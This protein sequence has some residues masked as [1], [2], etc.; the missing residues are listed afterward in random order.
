MENNNVKNNK[1]ISTVGNYSAYVLGKGI[2]CYSDMSSCNTI[3]ATYSQ[4]GW[5]DGCRC[6]RWQ[7]L[8]PP[9]GERV[10]NFQC[11][12]Y[13]YGLEVKAYVPL[14]EVWANPLKYGV[15]YMEIDR[16]IN[17]SYISIYE[18]FSDYIDCIKSDQEDKRVYKKDDRWYY[19]MWDTKLVGNEL[20]AKGINILLTETSMRI[21]INNMLKIDELV[22]EL[23]DAE[24]YG[25][26]WKIPDPKHSIYNKR[27]RIG[28]NGC[29][30]ERDNTIIITYKY[31]LTPELLKLIEENH[32]PK[33]VIDDSNLWF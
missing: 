26:E 25:Y 28:T 32:K 18:L 33:E 12:R 1:T 2:V 19:Y 13:S 20:E 9:Y 23:D 29:W 17:S 14:M 27:Y 24:K 8:F 7:C 16:L 5:K 21:I 31:D 6:R 15:T 22:K 30:I 10:K 3:A 4:Y 11:G